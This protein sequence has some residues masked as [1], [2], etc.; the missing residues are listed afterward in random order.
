MEIEEIKEGHYNINIS[1]KKDYYNIMKKN[2]VENITVVVG[3][4]GAGKTSWIIAMAE[5]LESFEDSSFLFVYADGDNFYIECNKILIS[6]FNGEYH[7]RPFKEAVIYKVNYLNKSFQIFGENKPRSK[8]I[9]YIMVRNKV[10]E[11]THSYANVMYSYIARNGMQY[12]DRSIYYKFKYLFYNSTNIENLDKRFIY[13][14]IEIDPKFKFL[15]YS[16]RKVHLVPENYPNKK[17]LFD[18]MPSGTKLYK[19]AFLL[20][21][22]ENIF[23]SFRGLNTEILKKYFDRVNRLGEEFEYDVRKI[24]TK[25]DEI[26]DILCDAHSELVENNYANKTDTKLSFRIYLNK[27]KKMMDLIPLKCMETSEKIMISLDLLE[28][29]NELRECLEEVFRDYDKRDIKLDYST[30]IEY[31]VIGLS[32]GFEFISNLYG[33]IYACFKLY[34][35]EKNQKIILVLDEPDCYMHPEWS[36][37]L[38][39]DL[40]DFLQQEF[41]DFCFEII[42]TTHSPYILSDVPADNVIFIENG[43]VCKLQI[44]T[45]G[46]NIHMLL[47]NS[48]FLDSTIGEFA[49]KN[50]QGLFEELKESDN[51]VVSYEKKQEFV[52]RINMI[53]ETLVRRKLEKIYKECFNE[54]NDESIVCLKEEVQKKENKIKALE[55]EIQELRGQNND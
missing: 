39:N 31:D 52:R 20:R 45:F 26:V 23:S 36:R 27:V 13:V 35:P 55:L 24:L 18:S 8:K 48:F 6:D 38:I 7:E 49:L 32:D 15:M 1:K 53:G 9:A 3:K 34:Q 40:Y 37:R 2:N 50:I 54:N 30:L 22:V 19:E 21:L 28:K 25:W 4:N 46:Q 47:K 17:C 29:K 41:I 44:E 11:M 51:I 14:K 16:D 12:S 5:L 43:K 42:L 33:V 10:N